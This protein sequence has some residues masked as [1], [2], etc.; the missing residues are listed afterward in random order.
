LTDDG[1]YWTSKY[2]TLVYFTKPYYP[3]QFRG[4]S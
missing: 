2:D 4:I 3:M 1:Q